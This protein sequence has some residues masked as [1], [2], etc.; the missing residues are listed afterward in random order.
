MQYLARFELEQGAVLQGIVHFPGKP[1]GGVYYSDDWFERAERLARAYT[2]VPG[3]EISIR[4]SLRAGRLAQ[5]LLLHAPLEAEEAFRH[6][7][8]GYLE[9]GALVENSVELPF[10]RATHDLRAQAW[11]IYLARL[12][13]ERYERNAA[14]MVADFRAHAVLPDLLEEASAAGHPFFYQANLQSW[15]ISGE[16]ERRARRNLVALESAKGIPAELLKLEQRLLERGSGSVLLLEEY[17]GTAS[18]VGE[19]WLRLAL[20]R[21]FALR[22]AAARLPAPRIVFED[23]SNASNKG[24]DSYADAVASGFHDAVLQEPE[25]HRLFASIT[26]AA[27]LDELLGWKRRLKRWFEPEQA[28]EQEQV[29]AANAAEEQEQREEARAAAALIDAT[30]LPISRASSGYLFISYRRLDFPRIA[31]VLKKLSTAKFPFWF[32]RGIPGSSEWNAVIEERVRHCQVFL[33]FLSQAAVDS[34]H[35]R[36]EVLLADALDKPILSLRI[37]EPEL[38]HGMALLLSQYQIL[39]I[40]VRD[41]EQHLRLAWK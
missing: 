10:D 16:A 25:L 15:V 37:E 20:E 36:R 13:P 2:A 27:D 34:K 32:D 9:L 5:T 39:D 28:T 14:W 30:D 41:L 19:E 1:R 22:F 23:N 7:L 8:A 29:L 17:V 26:H 35:V 24:S 33:L 38:R 21:K 31:S 3:C 11:P 12:E 18:P 6:Y 40:R 4:A